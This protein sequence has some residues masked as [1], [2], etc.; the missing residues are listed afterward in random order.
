[1]SEELYT[2][3]E[4]AKFLRVSL[5][6]VDRLIKSGKLKARKVGRQVRMTRSDLEDCLERGVIDD[7]D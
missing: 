6:T 3:E 4:A 1:M 7:S 5:S 2:R